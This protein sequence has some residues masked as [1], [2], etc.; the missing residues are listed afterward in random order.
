MYRLLS[1]L[2]GFCLFPSSLWAFSR[3]PWPLVGEAKQEYG[4]YPFSVEFVP[5]C[6]DKPK[7]PK[8]SEYSASL[9]VKGYFI[10]ANAYSERLFGDDEKGPEVWVGVWLEGETKMH[11]FRVKGTDWRTDGKNVKALKGTLTIK[12]SADFLFSENGAQTKTLRLSLLSE[13]GM[14][15]LWPRLITPK[16]KTFRERKQPFDQ[17]RY[18]KALQNLP[19]KPPTDRVSLTIVQKDCPA[20]VPNDQKNAPLPTPSAFSIEHWLQAHPGEILA[21]QLSALLLLGLALLLRRARSAWFL[22][23]LMMLGSAT[24]GALVFWVVARQLPGYAYDLAAGS[25]RYLL[26]SGAWFGLMLGSLFSPW[27]TNRLL[28]QRT[29]SLDLKERQLFWTAGWLSL[30]A[31]A[32]LFWVGNRW[33]FASLCLGVVGYL[34]Y[35]LLLSHWR[36]KWFEAVKAGDIPGLALAPWKEHSS[37]KLLVPVFYHPKYEELCDQVVL[38]VSDEQAP[39]RGQQEPLWLTSLPQQSCAALRVA[40]CIL[41]LTLIGF[42]AIFSLL[43]SL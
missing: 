8:C 18:Y 34:C 15:V 5:A 7:A 26:T 41:L 33:L 12:E 19:A 14:T 3:F 1:L 24:L 6:H 13:D 28:A 16:S 32:A 20:P 43:L 38:R 27:F 17:P 23:H 39:Y 2:L 22:M 4:L 35:S 40:A 42:S 29:P 31:L 37:E 36:V 21:G 11:R 10:D 9:L 30:S 25:P